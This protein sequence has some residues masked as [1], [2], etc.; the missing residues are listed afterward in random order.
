MMDERVKRFGLKKPAQDTMAQLIVRYAGR[1]YRRSREG[2]SVDFT[3][4]PAAVTNVFKRS[5][6]NMTDDV[7]WKAYRKNVLGMP[8]DDAELTQDQKRTLI[9]TDQLN[10]WREVKEKK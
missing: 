5:F 10:T 7:W 4:N 9:N 6:Q 3:L 8:E 1:P 2:S